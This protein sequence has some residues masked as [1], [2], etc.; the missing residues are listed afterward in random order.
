LK[1]RTKKLLR[2]RLSLSGEAEAKDRKVFCFFLSKKKAFLYPGRL[3]RRRYNVQQGGE[4]GRERG[5]ESHALAGPR[6]GEAKGGGV[7]GLARE[8]QQSGSD[9]RRQSAAG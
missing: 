1:K 7:Q 6:V 8:V 3:L 4:I 9:R 5:F 2:S